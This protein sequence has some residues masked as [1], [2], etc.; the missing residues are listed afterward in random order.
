MRDGT[1]RE[2][3]ENGK[4]PG[5]FFNA[6]DLVDWELVVDDAYIRGKD[7]AR[8][9]CDTAIEKIDAGYKCLVAYERMA[10]GGSEGYVSL[11]A[12]KIE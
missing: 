2:D 11:Y 8:R 10:I 7:D 3:F 1:P 5:M 9:V 12:K 6:S 4:L